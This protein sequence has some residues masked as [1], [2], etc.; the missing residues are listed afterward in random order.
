VDRCIEK[1]ERGRRGEGGTGG[2]SVC[3][4]VG[5]EKDEGGKW[6]R[7]GRERGEC[8]EFNVWKVVV[9]VVVV[10][11]VIVVVGRGGRGG[12]NKQE[13]KPVI[14]MSCHV[15]MSL[16]SCDVITHA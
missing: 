6:R 4:P 12:G 15:I 11:V 13:V 14:V 8:V 10:V 1:E 16:S 3:H 7:G 9:V 2:A 5:N